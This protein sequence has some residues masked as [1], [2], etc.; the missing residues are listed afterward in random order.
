MSDKKPIMEEYNISSE[1]LPGDKGYLRF[2]LPYRIEHW[3]FMIS[4]TTLGITGLVQKFA[5]Q[6]I[7]Q[8]IINLLGGIENTRTI[9]HAAAIV[10]MFVV[11]YH[12]GAIGYR[13][14]VH[15][16][17]FT[18]LPF[19]RDLTNAT[20]TLSYNV[21]FTKEKAQQDRYT[22]EEKLEYWAVV[23]GTVIMGITGFM[24]WNPLLTTSIL[25]G[26]VI[27]AAKV[28]HGLEA[29]LAVVSIIFWHMYSVFIK[30]FNKSMYTGF[31]SEHEMVDEHP[32]ELA[33]IKAGIDKPQVDKETINKRRRIYLPIY[34]AIA[35]IMVIG[36]YFFVAY[37]VTAITTVPPREDVEV[38][39][40]LTPTPIPTRMPTATPVP[41][42][43]VTWDGGVGELFNTKCSACHGS[44]QQL[45]GLDL[46]TYEGALSDG[47]SGPGI[48]PG[49]P[50]S[51]QVVIVQGAGNHPGQFTDE[52][53]QLIIEW[54]ENGAPEN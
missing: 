52:E 2:P 9:H 37:E 26:E 21:G 3:L 28:A 10:M 45:G 16:I 49:D 54:I 34:A 1:E 41:V 13:V 29:I 40:P 51:S 31:I 38:F 12:I 47:N 32:I 11:I 18:M 39:V 53:L 7:S 6:P 36:V 17:R 33:N 43:T 42:E 50:E 23:W 8:S 44:S 27:P 5:T 4:F 15:R 22:F 48:V 25:P 19:V 35:V 46:S 24:M 30:H 20:K 14:Y